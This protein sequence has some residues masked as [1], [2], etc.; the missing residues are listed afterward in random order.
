MY[1]LQLQPNILRPQ[2][3]GLNISRITKA[4][5]IVNIYFFGAGI[6]I[7]GQFEDSLPVCLRLDFFKGTFQPDNQ[8]SIR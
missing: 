3:N 1:R 2:L 7:L 5:F 4:G 8:T 6:E